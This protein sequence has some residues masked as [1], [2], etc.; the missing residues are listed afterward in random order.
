MSVYQLPFGG[1]FNTDTGQSYSNSID[2]T[3]ASIAQTKSQTIGNITFDLN[4]DK[5]GNLLG[6]IQQGFSPGEARYEVRSDGSVFRWSP[7]GGIV[8]DLG[9]IIATAALAYGLPVAGSAL[10]A[11]L[12]IGAAGGS[13]LVGAGLGAAQGQDLG[14]IATNA[15]IGGAAGALGSTVSTGTESQVAGQL[16]GGTTSGLLRGQDLGTAVSNAALTT[17]ANQAVGGLLNAATPTVDSTVPAAPS[18]AADYST[19]ADYSLAPTATSGLGLQATLAPLDMSNPYSFDTTASGLGF[20]ASLAPFDPSNPYSLATNFGNQDSMGGGT[21]IKVP[22]QEGATLGSIGAETE[23]STGNPTNSATQNL[24]AKFLLSGLTGNKTGTSNI[25]T[26]NNALLGG[27]LGNAL[28]GASGLMQSNT[29][30]AAYQTQADALRQ[31][32][33]VAANQAQFRPVGTTTT[34]GTSN[35]TVDPTTGQLT[36]AGYSLSPQLQ[37]YQNQIMGAGQQS[38]AD[39]AN[40]QNLGRGYIAQTPEQAAQQYMAKQQALLQ[41]SRDMESAR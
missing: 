12:G 14:Q 28:T 37:A 34:F 11:E 31:A 35:F 1:W 21:G 36:S 41:P 19:G 15:A 8:S 20:Q 22:T 26:N 40:L 33:Q 38:L 30:Q 18:S 13:A 4:Y 5:N 7:S 27:L 29:N 10:G 9:P 3:Q 23:E 24:L 32:G 39:A 17:G 2:A 25:A 16:A 6:G